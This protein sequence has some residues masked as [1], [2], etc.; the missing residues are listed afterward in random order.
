MVQGLCRWLLSSLLG[1]T[2][3]EKVEKPGRFVIALAPHTSNWDFLVGVLAS[4][5]SGFPCNFIMKSEWFFWPLGG[6]MRRLGGI[7][8]K[9]GRHNNLVRQLA[10]VAR[11]SERFALCITP[12]GTRKNQTHWHTGFYYIAL[13]AG[14]PVL[15]YGLDYRRR[16][17][18]CTRMMVPT[19]DVEA[20]MREVK[21]FFT[22][23]SAKHPKR[24]ATGL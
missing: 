4:H 10:D 24:F 16:L 12:E 8:V 20:D 18:S 7:P 13:E 17:I 15:L 1:F 14:I 23:F 21:L 2:L 11:K 3:E 6:L 9:R 19:G 22:Q 5:A